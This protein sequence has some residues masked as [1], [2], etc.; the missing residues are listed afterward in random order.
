MLEWLERAVLGLQVMPWLVVVVV[1]VSQRVAVWV[2]G[3]C[4]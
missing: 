3:P 1:V 2:H 4:Q